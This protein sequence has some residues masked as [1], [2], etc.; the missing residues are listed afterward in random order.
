MVE[1]CA[2]VVSFKRGSFSKAL[3]EDS[4]TV[5][6]NFAEVRSGGSW[7]D[8]R[9]VKDGCLT[10]EQWGSMVLDEEIGEGKVESG[11][12]GGEKQVQGNME[13]ERGW[14]G[15]C[16]SGELMKVMEEKDDKRRYAGEGKGS[17]CE[18]DEGRESCEGNRK[19]VV[20]V[21]TGNEKVGKDDS[22]KKEVTCGECG[23]KVANI[24]NLYRHQRTV[25]LGRKVFLS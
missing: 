10:F 13:L 22:K 25:H 21:D 1:S 6:V 8:R 3:C 11:N 5:G 24:S 16:G 20:D 4:T 18:T 17:R 9:Y 14:E 19:T 12:V 23:T 2:S 7:R 15:G